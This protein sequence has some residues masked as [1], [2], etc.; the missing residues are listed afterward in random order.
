VT[1]SGVPYKTGYNGVAT[2]T[3][4]TKILPD[5]LFTPGTH[6]EYF[7]FKKELGTGVTAM[8]P[9][10]NLVW[11]QN[12]ESNF[13]GHRWQ[14]FSVLP[15]A[16]KFSSYGGL[17]KACML[18]VDW[19]DR[20][21]T[22]RVWVSVADSI[23]ATSAA[24]KGA[25]NG[26]IA[27]SKVDINDPAYFVNKNCQPGTTWDMYG[28]KAIESLNSQSGSL[29]ARL[30]YRGLGT[31]LTDKWAKNAPTPEML[32]AYYRIVMALTGGLNTGALFGPFDDRSQDDTEIL[33]QFVIGAT[34][35][36][37]RGLFI[38]G[39]AAMEDMDLNGNTT[40]AGLMSSSLRE[41]SYLRFSG[42]S[43]PCID[44]IP[45]SIITTNGDIYGIRNTCLQTLD[46]LQP[47]GD[48]VAASF[49]DPVNANPLN[50]PYVA[51]VF[52]DAEPTGN[53]D[54]HW[55]ALL[56]GFD[57]FN[58]R[59]RLCDKTYGRLAYMW[60]VYTNIFGK[61]CSVAGTGPQTVE[62]P[63]ISEGRTFVEFAGQNPLR[64]GSAEIRFGLAKSDRVTVKIYDV[65]GRLVRTLADNQMFSPRDSY[66]LTWDGLD[67]GGRS[68]AR[69]A[70]FVNVRM[71]SSRIDQTNKMIV[72]K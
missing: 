62:V 63:N 57:T 39:D 72:L 14:Q 40:L 12:A 7:F 59:S 30:S 23:G 6:V 60:N 49:Y 36:A 71:A 46:V 33:R 61:I 24:R 55:Q 2:T 9:D 19:N 25:H 38:Q 58:L 15:D 1:A 18:Y 51:S 50:A 65:S 35:T 16:W 45:T 22:E 4:G 3:E 56:D 43:K 41:A 66:S 10:T 52:T 44:L 13:D 31:F 64:S 37:H 27:P 47:Q 11:P 20:N 5:G 26:W 28:I 68:V 69:G 32:E 17:G 29:G 8:V 34:G 42:N 53:P 67:N 21:G 54:N 48:G 70:Y